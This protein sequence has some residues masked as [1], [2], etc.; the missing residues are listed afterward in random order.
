MRK[1]WLEDG[2]YVQVSGSDSFYVDIDNEN[3]L[4]MTRDQLMELRSAIDDALNTS[5]EELG[6]ELA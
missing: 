2:G 5:A 4:S 6:D 3:G 1:F